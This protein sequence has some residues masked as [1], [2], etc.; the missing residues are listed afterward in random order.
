[1]EEVSDEKEGIKAAE[2]SVAARKKI[3]SFPG[4]YFGGTETGMGGGRVASKQQ[5]LA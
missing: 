2:G 4:N 5:L 1:M 3:S